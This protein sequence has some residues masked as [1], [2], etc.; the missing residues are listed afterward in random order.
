MPLSTF[1]PPLG[2]VDFHTPSVAHAEGVAAPT[3][4]KGWGPNF[5]A[6]DCLSAKPRSCA[7]ADAC[8]CGRSGQQVVPLP[9]IVDTGCHAAVVSVVDRW[10]VQADDLPA[11]HSFVI[12]LGQDLDAVVSGLSSG[13][14]E[15]HNNDQASDPRQLWPA[16]QSGPPHRARPFMIAVVVTLHGSGTKSDPEPLFS[17]RRQPQTLGCGIVLPVT[18][19]VHLN[20]GVASSRVPDTRAGKGLV[21]I[22]CLIGGRWWCVILHGISHV[23]P[24]SETTRGDGCFGTIL[25]ICGPRCR[26]CCLRESVG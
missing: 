23:Q 4:S 22:N 20:S 1:L 15:G 14:V 16:P 8:R 3:L 25:A 11:L 18:H 19:A 26:A 7:I 6:R 5:S 2:E 21:S 9:L 12:G 10:R 13:A 17:R 24:C